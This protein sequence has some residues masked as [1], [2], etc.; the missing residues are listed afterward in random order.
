MTQLVLTSETISSREIADL[1]GKNHAHVMRN[2]REMEPAWEK[3]SQSKFGLAEYWDEQGKPRPMYL[4]SKTECLYVATKFNDEARAKLVLRWEKLETE[5]RID[6]NNPNTILQLAQNWADEQ[7]KRIEAERQLVHKT[8][9]LAI[10]ERV[11]AESAP[12]VEYYEKVLT[13]TDTYLTNQIAKELGISA[14]TLNERLR[15]KGIQYKQG[16]QWLLSAKFQGKGLTKTHTYPFMRKDGSTGSQ[17]Q[18]VWTEKGRLFVH[19][20]MQPQ[21][22]PGEPW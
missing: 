6:F 21:L 15:Q 2:I 22:Q 19:Q 9:Q 8:E 16:G 10:Q 3:V 12:K 11:V 14:I 20:V 13:S 7:K 4:L 5:N 1:T 18:T 17:M